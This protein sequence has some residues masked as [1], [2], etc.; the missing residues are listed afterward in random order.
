LFRWALVGLRRLLSGLLGGNAAA[1]HQPKQQKSS[2]PSSR[3]HG[4]GRTVVEQTGIAQS[5]PIVGVR[6]VHVVDLARGFQR[7]TEFTL[8][9]AHPTGLG[10]PVR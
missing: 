8:V 10:W 6:L 3:A 9:L 7:V 2:N 5:N 1:R 4:D